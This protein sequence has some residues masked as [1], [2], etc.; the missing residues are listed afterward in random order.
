MDEKEQQYER[1]E[2]YLANSLPTGERLAFENEL[3]QDSALAREL[4]LHRH[5]QEA[6]L[7]EAPDNRMA[8]AL[9][10]AAND[11]FT[12]ALQSVP[13]K[14][15]TKARN[16]PFWYWMAASISLALLVGA[17]IY[18]LNSSPS[19]SPQALYD[20]NFSAYEAPV[21]FRS[22]EKEEV[23]TLKAAFVDYNR[24]EYRKA[25]D[26]FAKSL[27]EK[28]GLIVPQFYIGQCQLALKQP[29]KAI[30]SFEKVI[31]HGDN[32]YVM[33]ARWYLALAYLA[34]DKK[35]QATPLL[36]ELSQQNSAF[37]EQANQILAE[38]PND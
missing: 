1:I 28:P 27:Q 37:S 13:G 38:L 25:A 14:A 21:L 31:A 22:G 7:R 3:R 30:P 20:R 5:L 16:V 11:Y 19:M 26:L 23:S 6:I 15:I 18:F 2:Q 9:G 32:A 34:T 24:K 12:D 8:Q 4:V 35:A 17:G 33:Q 36:R 10:H 29:Q